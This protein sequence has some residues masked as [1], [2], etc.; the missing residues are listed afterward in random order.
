VTPESGSGRSIVGLLRSTSIA[1]K[2]AQVEDTRDHDAD[3][4]QC[5]WNYHEPRPMAGKLDNKESQDP[6]RKGHAQSEPL[7]LRRSSH[8]PMP[9]LSSDGCPGLSPA[10][11]ALLAHALLAER[12]EHGPVGQ[13]HG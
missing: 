4:E 7:H 2:V 11:V 12:T 8:S 3:D 10:N 6:Q 5:L 13:F 9:V 1:T